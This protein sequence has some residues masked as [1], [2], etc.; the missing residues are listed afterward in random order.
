MDPCRRPQGAATQN[1]LTPSLATPGP[2]VGGWGNGSSFGCPERRRTAAAI[3]AGRVREST[4][5]RRARSVGPTPGAASLRGP[6]QQLPRGPVPGRPWQLLTLLK[7]PRGPSLQFGLLP[8]QQQTHPQVIIASVCRALAVWQAWYFRTWIIFDSS[9]R[10]DT[11]VS[12][13]LPV[14]K[15]KA[16]RSVA[17]FGM[18]CKVAEPDL[19]LE[20]LLLYTQCNCRLCTAGFP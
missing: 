14:N 18:F 15:L 1:F 3:P 16:Q 4:T 2:G 8:G 11:V 13:V 10:W 6:R 5:R 17:F 20:A 12:P 7:S 9:M 19:F